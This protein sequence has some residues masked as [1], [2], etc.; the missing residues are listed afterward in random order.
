MK[1]QTSDESKKEF[2]LAEYD[3]IYKTYTTQITT[4]LQLISG[5]AV[6]S[7]TVIGMGINAQ[8][9]WLFLVSALI[10]LIAKSV[11][12]R[13]EKTTRIF[14]VRAIQLENNLGDKEHSIVTSWVAVIYGYDTMK[15]FQSIAL[16][17]NVE[18]QLEKIRHV[19]SRLQ[20][21][22][23]IRLLNF[24]VA[25]QVVIAIALSTFLNWSFF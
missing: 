20:S 4:L 17:K 25:T 18:E 2:R 8:K 16:M 24:S 22:K 23:Y 6:L 14:L 7:I 15:Q 19:K 1:I 21:D 12:L 10:S 11:V 5:F 9:S 13:G 3:N